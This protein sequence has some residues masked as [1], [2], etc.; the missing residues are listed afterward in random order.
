MLCGREYL[1]RFFPLNAKELARSGFSSPT[2]ALVGQLLYKWFLISGYSMTSMALFRQTDIKF[3]ISASH[4]PRDTKTWKMAYDVSKVNLLTSI[5]LGWTW[6][7][8]NISTNRGCYFATPYPC[9][10]N[11]Q[12]CPEVTSIETL[13]NAD[14]AWHDLGFRKSCLRSRVMVKS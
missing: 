5:T 9:A 2:R 4:Y 3:E 11:Q 13:R 7:G 10:N 14:F 1:L 6:K 8:H 12:K